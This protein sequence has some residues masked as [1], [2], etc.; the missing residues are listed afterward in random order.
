ML[1]EIDSHVKTKHENSIIVYIIMVI[2][3]TVKA[4]CTLEYNLPRLLLLN[5]IK[6]IFE[7][8]CTQ[9]V[10]NVLNLNLQL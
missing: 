8:H 7:I 2:V 4:F 10:K 1:E 6:N 9:G 5:L 3:I